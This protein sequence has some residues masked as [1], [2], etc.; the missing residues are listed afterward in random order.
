MTRSFIACQGLRNH[1]KFSCL[2]FLKVAQ[3][4]IFG[5]GRFLSCIEMEDLP[6]MHQPD[7][8]DLSQGPSSNRHFQWKSMGSHLNRHIVF[9]QLEPVLPYQTC[10]DLS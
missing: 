8:F 10:G 3:T 1:R 6:D 5:L 4:V 9:R 2:E 7:Q